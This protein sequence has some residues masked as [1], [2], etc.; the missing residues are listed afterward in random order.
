MNY[1]HKV[2]EISLFVSEQTP[3][4]EVFVR[5]SRNNQEKII[6]FRTDDL[7]EDQPIQTK[8]KTLKSLKKDIKSPVPAVKYEIKLLR[9]SATKNKESSL[10]FSRNIKNI[11]LEQEQTSTHMLNKNLN[12]GQINNERL[13]T[14]SC[15]KAET[16]FS[17]NESNVLCP[18]K[19]F[20]RNT[21][22]GNSKALVLKHNLLNETKRRIPNPIGK[23]NQS[24]RDPSETECNLI[25]SCSLESSI[26]KS[27]SNSIDDIFPVNNQLH[28]FSVNDYIIT[29]DI[30]E[31]IYG[32]FYSA[33]DKFKNE[34]SLLKYN[35]ISS[36]Q[37][38]MFF[39]M[40]QHSCFNPHKNINRILA[41]CISKLGSNLFCVSCLA[42]RHL[43]SLEAHTQQLKEKNDIFLEKD[44]LLI[45]KG[46]VCA[47]IFLNKNSFCHGSISPSSILLEK[48]NCFEP[49]ISLPHFIDPLSI[50]DADCM[51]FAK[52]IFRKNENFISPLVYSA[53]TKGRFDLKHD[54]IKSDIY[55]LGA[56][57]VYAMTNSTKSLFQLRSRVDSGSSK[58]IILQNMKAKYSDQFVNLLQSMLIID[59][60][61]RINL[62]KISESIERLLVTSS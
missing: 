38:E 37:V 53:F 5:S 62:T 24:K 58:Q 45:L 32:K 8:I 19:T 29:G 15:L 14:E 17:I 55:S 23:S 51:K 39:Q 50:K 42:N 48:V 59:E 7:N 16:T 44:L 60:K 52:E 61:K 10:A 49:M 21:N 30:E 6:S 1:T 20:T 57:I 25:E 34:Y 9:N 3:S 13:N 28:S 43:F 33:I 4:P 54:A 36:K 12:E 26:K 40:L 31:N 56:A 46:V 41:V 2:V 27:Q 35:A 47:L 11:N 18:K 22:M